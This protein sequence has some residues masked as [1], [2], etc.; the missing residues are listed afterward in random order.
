M[1]KEFYAEYF[2]IEDKHW[3]F[4]G[5]RRIFLDIL[6]KY[7]PKPAGGRPRRIL[8][9]GCG[10]GTMLNYLSRYGRAEGIDADEEAVR[11]CHERGITQVRQVSALPLPFEDDT[12][13]LVTALDVIEHIEDDLGTL[14]E[15]YRVL[16]P[17]GT[18]LMSVPAYKFLW[19]AQDEISNHKRRYVAP[20]VR[21]R[22]RATGFKVR[23]LSYFNTFLFPIIA[24]IRLV[25]PYKPGSTDLKSDFTMTKGGLS[26]KILGY[27]FGMEAPLVTRLNLPFG[28]SILGLA[29]KPRKADGRAAE[30]ERS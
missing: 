22:L 12:F 16:R 23:R 20:Q 1:H 14:R 9:M 5:R 24:G 11:F 29:Y 26:N 3:W 7:L 10:T 18:L 13:D 4:V 17:G 15:L 2:K 19:G 25:R 28:V 6:D 8:D 27:L 21:E 30:T